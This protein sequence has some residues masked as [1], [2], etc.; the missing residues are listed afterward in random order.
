MEKKYKSRSLKTKLISNSKK[1]SYT[2]VIKF[3]NDYIE[4]TFDGVTAYKKAI[5]FQDNIND[6]IISILNKTK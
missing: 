6:L 2:L 4:K 5:L 3:G 1:T